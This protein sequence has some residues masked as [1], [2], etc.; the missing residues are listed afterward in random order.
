MTARETYREDLAEG[1]RLHVINDATR[2]DKFGQIKLCLRL[3]L[4][5]LRERPS[6][7]ISTGAAPGYF[8]LVFGK[9]LFARTIWIDSIANA[10]EISMT[11][12]MVRRFADLYL[13]Q[14]PHLASP[15]GPA[16]KGAVL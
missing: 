15:E 11:G 12:R 2:W 3:L 16:Y 7:V 9:I 13:T 6:V 5:L 8:A 1:A 10:E 14:W 4:I